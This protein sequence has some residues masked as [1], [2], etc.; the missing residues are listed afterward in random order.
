MTN[1]TILFSEPG[2][3]PSGIHRVFQVGPRK[4][5]LNRF[6]RRKHRF[7]GRRVIGH[8]V[9]SPLRLSGEITSVKGRLTLLKDRKTLPTV[10]GARSTEAK[11]GYRLRQHSCFRL[12]G[13]FPQTPSLEPKAPPTDGLEVSDL[14]SGPESPRDSVEETFV[15]T[16]TRHQVS[17]VRSLWTPLD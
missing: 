6:N 3:T 11:W 4:G 17:D 5:P 8:R 1:D 14:H 9:R 13:L 15:S 16:E 7:V 12:W 2:L 10:K